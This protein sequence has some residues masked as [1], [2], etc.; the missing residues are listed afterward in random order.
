MHI[1]LAKGFGYFLIYQWQIKKRE[2]SLTLI[3]FLSLAFQSPQILVYLEKFLKN[4][5][6]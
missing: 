1:Q 2:D 4:N 3:H 6:K 5:G